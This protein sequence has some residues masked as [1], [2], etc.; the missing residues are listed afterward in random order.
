MAILVNIRYNYTLDRFIV[1][2]ITKRDS[3]GFNTEVVGNHFVSFQ[4]INYQNN[5]TLSKNV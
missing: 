2:D 1:F 5:Y 4:T 3:T